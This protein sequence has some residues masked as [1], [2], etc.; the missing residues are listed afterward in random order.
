MILHRPN[1][2]LLL[3][4]LPSAPFLACH[5]RPTA[6]RR[7]L[8]SQ[9]LRLPLFASRILSCGRRAS[10]PSRRNRPPPVVALLAPRGRAAPRRRH[11]LI[12][13]SYRCR[14]CRPS[15]ASVHRPSSVVRRPSCDPPSPVCSAMAPLDGTWC[16]HRHCRAASL[17]LPPLPLFFSRMFSII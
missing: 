16:R 15:Y 4:L 5:H 10:V 7:P 12:V 11:N 6:P 14:R 1:G 9:A 2:H 3:L 17:S 13:V 8:R